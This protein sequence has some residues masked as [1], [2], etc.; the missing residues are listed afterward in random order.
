MLTS[1][2]IFA[3]KITSI[4]G[5]VTINT[6]NKDFS[7]D[8]WDSYRLTGVIKGKYECVGQ[9]RQVAPT[10][11]GAAS[12]TVTSIGSTANSSSASQSSE[13]DSG[14]SSGAKAGIGVGAAVGA[15][16]LVGMAVFI[17]LW[18]RKQKPDTAGEEWQKPEIDGH[19]VKLAS[20]G[21]LE[22]HY[23]DRSEMMTGEE[24]Q[25]LQAD[26]GTSEVDPTGNKVRK[27]PGTHEMG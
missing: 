24:A 13:P 26:H 21:E 8:Y 20:M 19:E 22:S 2:S 15:A 11:S 27:V 12:A 14:M 17:I 16:A 23:T 18:R 10:S 25:E 1:S 4:N 3:T 7:C 9:R 6:D 5:L